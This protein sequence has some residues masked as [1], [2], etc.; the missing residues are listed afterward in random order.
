MLDLSV[1]GRPYELLFEPGL[2]YVNR[3]DKPHLLQLFGI[4]AFEILLKVFDYFAESNQFEKVNHSSVDQVIVPALLGHLRSLLFQNK[5]LINKEEFELENL[6]L[7]LL[8]TNV[9][10]QLV[11][12]VFQVVID[13]SLLLFVRVKFKQLRRQSVQLHKVSLL[14]GLFNLKLQVCS[15]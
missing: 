8:L 12:I 14:K 13:G 5:I 1:L 11:F 10:S 2:D 15:F 9:A 3:P 4:Q 7:V 6:K